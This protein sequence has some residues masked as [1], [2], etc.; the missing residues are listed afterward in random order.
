MP[1]L[2]QINVTAN[3]GSHGK[4]AEDIGLLAID[5]GWESYIAYGRSAGE[6]KSRL[7]K[8]GSYFGILKHVIYSR[9]LDRHG[10]G[11]RNATKKLIKIIQKLTPDIIHIHNIH[12]YYLNYK[13]LFE[14]FNTSAI[15]VVWTLHDCWSFTGHCAYY[16]FL[17][18]EKWKEQCGHCPSLHS[19]PKSFL[20]DN[21][22]YNYCLKKRLF[23]N[24][25]NMMLIPV[26]NWL[27][28][29]VKKSFLKNIALKRIYNGI[30]LLKFRPIPVE[31]ENN[32]F[33]ILGVANI[34]EPRKGL[35]DFIELSRRISRDT[36]I[37][38]IG[39]NQKQIASLPN[40]IM[41]I[42][43]TENLQELVKYYSLADVF[44]NPTWEDNFPT[45]NLEA[46]ACGTPVITYKTGGSSEAIDCKTGIAVDKGNIDALLIAINEIRFQGK[47]YYTKNCV[48]RVKSFFDKNNQYIEYFDLY[49]SLL[50]NKK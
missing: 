30:D 43:R 35:D 45:T 33:I 27:A 47:T 10:L 39:L 5:K 19:Y 23:T 50:C 24:K 4:I 21:S 7:I 38:L 34:W 9:F 11:S 12:G 29:E 49:K 28:N 13:L 48:E 31:K 18:C 14:F 20:Y 16:D 8:I 36:L 44:V 42:S 15:P 26:S 32:K 46:M 25:K 37:I 1:V 40:N 17:K 6:S 41:G 3:S 2:F 22:Q